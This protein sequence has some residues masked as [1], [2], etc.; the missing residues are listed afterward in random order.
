M[1]KRTRQT[2]KKKLSIPWLKIFVV[3]L[4][5]TVITTG[6]FA[7][8]LESPM[9][10]TISY[11]LCAGGSP[12]LLWSALLYWSKGLEWLN[13]NAQDALRA[14]RNKSARRYSQRK[15]KRKPKEDYESS[16]Q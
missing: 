14:S 9:L 5:L 2:L 7:W 1:T 4:Y 16:S 11:A 8:F 10:S 15:A 3:T 13:N 12:F 6:I